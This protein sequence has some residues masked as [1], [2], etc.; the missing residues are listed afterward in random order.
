[1]DTYIYPEKATFKIYDPYEGLSDTFREYGEARHKGSKLL[2]FISDTI[3]AAKRDAKE[4]NSTTL[5][6]KVLEELGE[7]GT[8][9]AGHKTVKEAPHEE[10][11]DLVITALSLYALEGGS[12]EH[13]AEYGK[14]KLEKYNKKMGY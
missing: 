8:A 10:L 4:N 9:K 5:L 13:L 7:Y 11:V 12:I 1:M 2:V 3:N 6:Y 14:C